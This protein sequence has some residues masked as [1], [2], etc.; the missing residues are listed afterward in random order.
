MFAFIVAFVVFLALAINIKLRYKLNYVYAFP[1]SAFSIIFVLYLCGL[2]KCLILGSVLVVVGVLILTY[3]NIFK[4]KTT[5]NLKDIFNP[6]FFV[7]IAFVLV[8]FVVSWVRKAHN[9]DEFSHW[10]LIVK[11]MHYYNNFANGV[12]T[13]TVCNGYP[14]AVS[15]LLYFFQFF[16][17]GFF[18]GGLFVTLNLLNL[19]LLLPLCKSFEE[20]PTIASALLSLIIC[21]LPIVV[22]ADFYSSLLIDAYLGLM[23]AYLVVSSCLCKIDGFWL[24][25]LS[26][27]SFVLVA[28]KASGAGLVVMA[29]IIIYLYK[30]FFARSSLKLCANKWKNL[31][32]LALPIA[33]VIMSKISWSLYIKLNDVPKAWGSIAMKDVF[34]LFGGLTDFQQSILNKFVSATLNSSRLFCFLTI[35]F[36]VVGVVFCIFKKMKVTEIVFWLVA[37]LF[38][39]VI[40]LLSLLIL[41]WFTFTPAEALALA[42]FDR[43]YGTIIVGISLILSAIIGQKIMDNYNVTLKEFCAQ[44]KNKGRRIL[45]TI[46]IAL[47]AF[48]SAS[49]LGAI[50]YYPALK[51]AMSDAQSSTY[52]MNYLSD[53][54]NFC[55]ELDPKTEKVFYISANDPGCYFV[56]LHYVISPV[57]SNY[58]DY[59]FTID[60]FSVDQLKEMISDYD[61][62]YFIFGDDV[63]ARDYTELF[64]DA[65]KV[66]DNTMF[67][68]EK[69]GT[70]LKLVWV[71]MK[72]Y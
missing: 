58:N 51:R 15:L 68:V 64:D 12:E 46:S 31:L 27:G 63:F 66:A 13:S 47:V 48:L 59:Y 40:Y 37:T 36:L 14:P 19:C 18:E 9:W 29:L 17:N 21:A 69:S 72:K 39:N 56:I 45:S 71:N 22:Y 55:K 11:N 16:G 70:D 1:F 7:V 41:Y 44:F 26:I 43:Y 2:F 28:S 8:N 23:F 53:L 61:Y 20:K 65:E 60:R 54:D 32:L 10:A 50:T 3:L 38:A 35:I 4:A 52:I 24:A 42:S 33:A 57:R 34:A 49:A 67:K 25:N 6:I 30:L 5:V 62:V